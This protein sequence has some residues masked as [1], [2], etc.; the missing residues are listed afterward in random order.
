MPGTSQRSADRQCLT[1]EGMKI[2]RSGKNYLMMLNADVRLGDGRIGACVAHRLFRCGR[3]G[4]MRCR[5]GS[6]D[7]VWWR[8]CANV[9]QVKSKPAVLCPDLHIPTDARCDSLGGRLGEKTGPDSEDEGQVMPDRV[10]FV[11]FRPQ[12]CHIGILPLNPVRIGLQPQIHQLA[13]V[14][15]RP[16]A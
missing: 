5:D 4:P 6:V 15:Q 11:S 14:L 3:I 10:R 9:A 8:V 7:I 12:R 16:F 13:G 1:P 2:H